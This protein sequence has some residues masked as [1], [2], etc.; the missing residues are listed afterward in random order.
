MKG[1]VVERA[2]PNN[3]IEVYP[4][5]REA[6]KAGIITGQAPSE[7]T[8]KEFYYRLLM[9]EL[10]HPGQFYYLARRSRGF[11]GLLHAVIVP[12]R[13]DRNTYSIF[14]DFVFVKEKR[15]KYGV[16]RKMLDALMNDALAIG[17]REFEFACPEDQVE[18]WSKERK[19]VKQ[20]A[21]MRCTNASI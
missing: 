13:W 18:Y 10:P 1:L 16:G 20:S 7:K 6:L 15:R 3:A 11:L 8:L 9:D 19:A 21:L 14:V 4:L 12:N 2:K 5:I 17:I